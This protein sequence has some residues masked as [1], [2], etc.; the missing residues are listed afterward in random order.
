MGITSNPLVK[1]LLEPNKF[2]NGIYT[3][4]PYSSA[5]CFH[6]LSIP[7]VLYRKDRWKALLLSL[8]LHWAS[9]PSP[10]V[11]W[12]SV[13]CLKDAMTRGLN[14]LTHTSYRSEMDHIPYPQIKEQM[15]LTLITRTAH[16]AS[17]QSA[18]HHVLIRSLM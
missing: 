3:V 18:N 14:L 7:K 9:H 15:Y 12:H 2:L 11:F 13:E 8:K 16:P 17:L 10:E 5:Y 6:T 4:L 1:S